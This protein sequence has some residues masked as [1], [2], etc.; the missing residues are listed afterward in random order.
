MKISRL[1]FFFIA[2]SV[3]AQNMAGEGLLRQVENKGYDI[4]IHDFMAATATNVVS[5]ERLQNSSARG[6]IVVKD[7]DDWKVRFVG[8]CS[9]SVCSSF[10]V[11]FDL[12]E[13]S[14]RLTEFEVPEVIP[15]E[16]VA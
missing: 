15:N 2:S 11:I 4:Y 16:Q 9:E 13:K 3:Y 7:A 12:E 6:W 1:I 8:E 14:S 10:D 5:V